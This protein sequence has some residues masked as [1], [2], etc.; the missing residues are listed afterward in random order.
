MA[1]RVAQGITSLVSGEV[2]L[3]INDAVVIMPHVKGGR[4]KG[5]ALTTLQPSALVPGAT[6]RHDLGPSRL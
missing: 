2:H 1:R 4:L 3:T 5:L 6:Y